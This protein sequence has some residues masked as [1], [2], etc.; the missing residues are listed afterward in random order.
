MS[1]T[2]EE[3]PSDKEVENVDV[4]AGSDGELGGVDKFQSRAERKA[5]K[6]LLG[7]GLKKINGINRVTMRKAKGVSCLLKLI[8][9]SASGAEF[10]SP[11]SVSPFL[12]ESSL[13]RCF[14]WIISIAS[15][16]F[17]H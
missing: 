11:E 16:L 6:A 1:A 10:G 9:S 13:E 2:I 3:I 15:D 4:D 14:Q 17:H 7:L 5:R 12:R 8:L